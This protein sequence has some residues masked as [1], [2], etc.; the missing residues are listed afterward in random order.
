M[1]ALY[2]IVGLVVG[3]ILTNFVQSMLILLILHRI[4]KN[5]DNSN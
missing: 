2:F 1:S 5:I 4:T 3:Y